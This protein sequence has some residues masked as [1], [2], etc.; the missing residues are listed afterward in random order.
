MIV[1]VQTK[2]FC[3]PLSAL[4]KVM[5]DEL[6]ANAWPGKCISSSSHIFLPVYT[7]YV[8]VPQRVSLHCGCWCSHTAAANATATAAAAAAVAAAAAAV[9][10]CCRCCCRPVLLPLLQPLPPLKQ[11][12]LPLLT[13]LCCRR[14]R[15]C[16]SVCQLH[17]AAV[18][19]AS[20]AVFMCT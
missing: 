12:Q 16:R 17:T 8:C 1:T 18:R 5:I 2:S 9:R 10:C 7:R 19:F 14:S 6:N 3:S 20:I 11:Q 4:I 15:C 13:L